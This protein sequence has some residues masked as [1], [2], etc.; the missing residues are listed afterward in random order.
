MIKLHNLYQVIFLTT[1]AISLNLHISLF[2][3]GISKSLYKSSA[4]CFDYCHTKYT[5]SK[6]QDFT[7]LYK[8]HHDTPEQSGTLF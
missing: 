5:I 6:A 4:Y 3:A 1:T 7:A 2:K 8:V